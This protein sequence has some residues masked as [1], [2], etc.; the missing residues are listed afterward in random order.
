MKKIANIL[1]TTEFESSS[2]TTQEF[3]KF[4]TEFKKEFRKEITSIGG[5]DIE[6]HV[7]H[8]DVSGFFEYNNQL[9]YFSLPDV[10]GSYY[11]CDVRMM[12]RTAQH[13]KDWK[14]GSNQ[15]VIIGD[16]MGKKM[17]NIAH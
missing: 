12:Y 2:T 6:F 11:G 7:G 4:V 1:R 8:F 13:R 3:K 10:R 16:D 9:Y 14:G 15:W 17:F 5:K